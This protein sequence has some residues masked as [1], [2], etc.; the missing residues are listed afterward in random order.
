[1]WFKREIEIEIEEE[2]DVEKTYNRLSELLKEETSKP[3]DEYNTAKID[4]LIAKLK[5]LKDLLPIEVKEEPEKKHRI[6]PPTG[7]TL[8][9]AGAVALVTGAAIGLEKGGNIWPKSCN[10]GNVFSG[11]KL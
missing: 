11:F 4:Y 10:L 3:I 8:V 7:D 6:S 2:T 9:K 1:M 5:E